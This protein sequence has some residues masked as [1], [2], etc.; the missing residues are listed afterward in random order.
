MHKTDSVTALFKKFFKDD[1]LEQKFI[2]STKYAK[3][4]GNHNF[5]IDM[6]TPKVVITDLLINGFVDLPRRSMF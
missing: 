4:K 6:D 2:E 1:I 3:L 5:D